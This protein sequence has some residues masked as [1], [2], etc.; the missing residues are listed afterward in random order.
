MAPW[1]D[2]DH[3]LRTRGGKDGG[4]SAVARYRLRRRRRAGAWLAV[5]TVVQLEANL[6]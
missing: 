3:R 5:E 2:S 6:Q 4:C 1:Q